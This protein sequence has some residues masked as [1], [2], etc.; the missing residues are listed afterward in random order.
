MDTDATQ[1]REPFDPE[2]L[3]EYVGAVKAGARFPPVVVF[4][5]GDN[6]VLADGHYRFRAQRR[7]GLK[8]VEVVVWGGTLRDAVRFSCGC[9]ADHG[10]RRT[11]ADKRKAVLTLL[12]DDEWGKKT[13]RWI[14]DVAKVSQPFVSKLRGEVKRSEVAVSSER[15]QAGAGDNR[16]HLAGEGLP[17]AEPE[18]E[19]ET[20]EGRDGKTYPAKRKAR[21]VK[22]RSTP[23]SK[24]AEPGGGGPLLGVFAQV[25]PLLD[26][27]DEIGGMHECR[28]S[29]VAVRMIA[30][31]LRRGYESAREKAR[32]VHEQIKPL[33]AELYY[34]GR[35]YSGL[36]A[37]GGGGGVRGRRGPLRG[38]DGGGRAPRPRRPGVGRRPRPAL[39]PARLRLRAAA[40]VLA[41]LPHRHRPGRAE[42]L[43]PRLLHL[44]LLSGRR[45]KGG[46]L[47]RTGVEGDQEQQR[48]RLA[49]PGG[50][51]PAL[52][53]GL[54]RAGDHP[55]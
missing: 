53:V 26:E 35:Q 33:I 50:L 5:D 10:L 29:P 23:A 4:R 32:D 47:Q 36:I 19:P 20:R 1:Q 51:R 16:Y 30:A 43:R 13:D 8:E 22:P 9:N 3:E 46:G 2:V 54:G 31:K 28:M 17:A 34:W 21:Q 38:P 18:P 39:R 49:R 55:T 44:H 37:P 48:H 27:L 24:A 25:P 45:L 52:V 41:A 14:S 40:R 15:H 12:R 11:N 42:R 6:Y 7:L